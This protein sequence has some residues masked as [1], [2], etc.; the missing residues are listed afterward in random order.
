[1]KDFLIAELKKLAEKQKGTLTD[2][3]YQQELELIEAIDW[4]IKDRVQEVHLGSVARLEMNGR[5]QWYF[6][7]PVGGGNFITSS[8]GPLLVVSAF[9]GLG[10]ELLGKKVGETFQVQ[11]KLFKLL[12]LH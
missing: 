8:L 1:M 10:Q 4:P 6:V 3:E 9:S 2:E 7:S 11:T 12:E 5:A